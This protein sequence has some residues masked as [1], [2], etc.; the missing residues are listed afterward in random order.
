MAVAKGL[1]DGTHLRCYPSY[2]FGA[3][4][5]RSRATGGYAVRSPFVSATS[6]RGPAKLGTFWMAGAKLSKVGPNTKALTLSDLQKSLPSNGGR[7]FH[8]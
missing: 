8:N 7:D 3:G 5:S 2:A 6:G 1:R 4:S